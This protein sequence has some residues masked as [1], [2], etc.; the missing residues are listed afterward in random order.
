MPYR[1][2]TDPE[3][4]GCWR[5]T[6]YTDRNGTPVVR[7]KRSQT[8]ARRWVWTRERGPLEDSQILWNL[9]GDK[10]CVNPQHHEPISRAEL[11]HR[12]GRV[13]LNRPIAR[14][15]QVLLARG[16]GV[17]TMA[18]VL[19]VDERTIRNIRDGQHW[20]VREKPDS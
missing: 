11:N 15:A 12:T 3:G 4:L 7:T 16:V 18:R 2:D 17:R 14:R 1:V 6:G 13:V 19:G 5:W 20:A 8:T 9:C 10:L